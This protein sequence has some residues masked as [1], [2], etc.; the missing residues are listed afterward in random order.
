[1]LNVFMSKLKERFLA[2]SGKTLMDADSPSSEVV[3]DVLRDG[4]S[5]GE[6]CSRGGQFSEYSFSLDRIYS[7]VSQ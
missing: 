1:M 2:E 7:S 6:F 4:I 3:Y 5:K